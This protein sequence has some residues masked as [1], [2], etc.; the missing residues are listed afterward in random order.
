MLPGSGAAAPVTATP[1]EET[2]V[3][4]VFELE[5]TKRGISAVAWG[6]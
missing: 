6:G 1:F 3:P 2:R 5:A 4:L